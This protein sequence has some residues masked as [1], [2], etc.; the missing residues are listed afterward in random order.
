MRITKL[1]L[2]AKIST[3]GA[4]GHIHLADSEYFCPSILEVPEYWR[5]VQWILADFKYIAQVGDCDDFALIAHATFRQ[6]QWKEGWEAP[7]AMG[8]VW[9]KKFRGKETNHAVNW[10]YTSDEGLVFAEPQWKKWENHW[11]AD[12]ENDSIYMVRG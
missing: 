9:G 2:A 12:V 11:K 1:N 7:W 6:M 4:E 5:I 10:F 8:E 3:F